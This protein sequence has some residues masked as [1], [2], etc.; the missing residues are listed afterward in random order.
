MD[1]DGLCGVVCVVVLQVVDLLLTHGADM[2]LADK[3]GRTPLMMAASEG[4]VD[5]VEFL[6]V[7]GEALCPTAPALHSVSLHASLSTPIHWP[8]RIGHLHCSTSSYG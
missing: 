7:Q 4:H 8:K 6:L 1:G 3:Q 5:T 2:N